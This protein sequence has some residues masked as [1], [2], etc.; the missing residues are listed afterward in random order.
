MSIDGKR[1][2]RKLLA[3][4]LTLVLYYVIHEGAHL[5]YALMAGS[6]RQINF[7]K[8]GVQIET[9]RERMSDVQTGI[10][11]LSG[12]AVTILI[13]YGLFFGRAWILRQKS[14]LF[15]ASAYYM[16][17]LFMLN[18]PFYLSVLYPYVGGGDMNGI[19]LLIPEL[20]ARILFGGI[21]LVNIFLIFRWLIPA[22]QKA[23]VQTEKEK[24]K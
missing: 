2:M 3:F 20:A 17:L 21:F 6:F 10:F 18:D 7:L 4:S 15:R 16:T 13:S 1:N 23:Y 5:I 22:Y 14:L 19:A 9:Y 8:L 12:P 11:C 24:Q